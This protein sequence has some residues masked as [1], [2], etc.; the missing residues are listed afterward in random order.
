MN[1]ELASEK[2]IRR[3]ND[4]NFW[5]I[6]FTHSNILKKLKALRNQIKT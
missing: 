4:E 6:C 3:K 5:F 2:V 1:G